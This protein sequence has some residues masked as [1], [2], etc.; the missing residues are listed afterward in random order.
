MCVVIRVFL[1]VSQILR[2]VVRRLDY[3]GMYRPVL[4][5]RPWLH[6][7]RWGTL[8]RLAPVSGIF[9]FDRGLCIDRYYMEVFLAQ[10]AADIRGD[11]L[12]IADAYYTRRFGGDRVERSH[13][14]HATEGNPLA[15]IVGDLVSGEGI[16]QNAFDCLLFTQTFPFI[17][18]VTSAVATSARLLRPGGV[19]L[20]TF[21]GISQI[22][23]YDMDRWGDYW[24]FTDASAQRLFGDVYGLQ[25]VTVRTYGNV[26]VA[27]AFLHGLAAH[28]LKETEL[29]YR[30]PDYQVLISVRAVKAHAEMS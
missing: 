21:P 3:A 5:R 17:Y 2:Q 14:L 29:E 7:V 18:D 12:E 24:R 4:R 9:G 10:H 28:E 16:S 19:L 11:V 20:A 15:T 1:L 23:R 22:S 30:D 8:R 26:L 25:N 13:V 27:C 6:S